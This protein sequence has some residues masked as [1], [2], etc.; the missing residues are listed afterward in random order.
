VV[1]WGC[2]RRSLI[3]RAHRSG[4]VAIYDAYSATKFVQV[5]VSAHDYYRTLLLGVDASGAVTS[6][7]PVNYARQ[8]P[9]TID[10]SGIART[11]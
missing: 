11:S 2:V 1:Q 9:Y 5:L 6:Q 10:V 3:D 8:A 7:T 4:G